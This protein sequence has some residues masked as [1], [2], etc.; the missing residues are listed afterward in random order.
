MSDV[1]EIRKRHQ[2]WTNQVDGETACDGCSDHRKYV[3]WPCDAAKL[4]ALAE[5]LARTLDALRMVN[6]TYDLAEADLVRRMTDALLA[7]PDVQALLE[8]SDG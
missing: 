2:P 5:K 6:P 8:G 4:L 7:E 1:A 3:L